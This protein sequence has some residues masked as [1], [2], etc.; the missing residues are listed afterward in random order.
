M[1]KVLS[2]LGSSIATSVLMFV[3]TG[4][5]KFEGLAARRAI[6]VVSPS[7][8]SLPQADS[9]CGIVVGIAWAHCP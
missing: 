6:E 4:E 3:R 1:L 2:A 7:I 8:P 5:W 9:R